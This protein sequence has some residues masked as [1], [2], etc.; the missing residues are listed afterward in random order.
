VIQPVVI[1]N[2][3][4]VGDLG[5]EVSR[6]LEGFVCAVWPNRVYQAELRRTGC[7]MSHFQTKVAALNALRR[8]EVDFTVTDEANA[9]ALVEDSGGRLTQ[10]GIFLNSDR[11][12]IVMKLGNYELK[13]G[14]DRALDDMR[15]DGTLR[16]LRGKHGI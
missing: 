2:Q 15:R 9:T 1:A 11:Y 5:M 4:R 13:R 8:G 3:Y 12:G 7:T 16:E 14:V 10:L 6:D